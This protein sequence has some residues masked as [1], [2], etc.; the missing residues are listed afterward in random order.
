MS[1]TARFVLIGV[2]WSGVAYGALSLRLIPGDYSHPFCGPWGCLPP[3]QALAAVHAFWI[4]A[5]GPPTHWSSRV[6][7]PRANRLVG[8]LISA[9]AIIGL[10]ITICGGSSSR[11]TNP[12]THGVLAR[13]GVSMVAVATQVDVP[14]IPLLMAGAVLWR[15][16]IRS[17]FP[18]PH[19]TLGRDAQEFPDG[20]ANVDQGHS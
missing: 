7:G 18:P 13:F 20:T 19:E 15:R 16:G 3:I 14:L 6:M 12:G 11:P 9:L 5:I 10:V 17:A 4:V 8:Q 1:K 2:S